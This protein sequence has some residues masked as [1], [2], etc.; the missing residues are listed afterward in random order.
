MTKIDRYSGTWAA[1]AEHVKRRVDALHL[2][3]ETINSHDESQI[4]RGRILE[5][6]EILNLSTTQ[7]PIETEDGTPHGLDQ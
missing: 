4:I 2:E 5:L 7:A 6:R 1:V 3:L